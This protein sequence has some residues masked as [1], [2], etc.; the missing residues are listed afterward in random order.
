MNNKLVLEPISL[1]VDN[2]VTEGINDL[3]KKVDF[4]EIV[5][6]DDLTKAGNFVKE[7]FD[8]KKNVEDQRILMTKPL[9]QALKNINA[10]FKKFSIP[11]EQIDILLRGKMVTFDNENKDLGLTQFGL[12]HFVRTNKI[13]VIDELAVPREYLS[14]NLAKVKV[15]ISEG[16]VV[17]GIEVTKESHVSL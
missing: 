13:K 14:V 1:S 6:P 9:N 10:F 8:L 4:T 5:N 7:V 2:K 12:I 16:K 11:L 3:K 15:A 17:P